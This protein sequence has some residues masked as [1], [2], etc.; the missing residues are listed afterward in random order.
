MPKLRNG[1]TKY[2]AVFCRAFSAVYEEAWARE[3]AGIP[4]Q[5]GCYG[6]SSSHEDN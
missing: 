3:A 6:D 4:A 1:Q 2:S 5:Q